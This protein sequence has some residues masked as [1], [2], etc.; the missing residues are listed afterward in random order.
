MWRGGRLVTSGP[1][2][3]DLESARH[4]LFYKAAR[5]DKNMSTEVASAFDAASSP[6]RSRDK[7]ASDDD[8]GARG[9]SDAGPDKFTHKRA[10]IEVGNRDMCY[11]K[12]KRKSKI[13]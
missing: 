3:G 8:H 11:R 6:K 4:H 7:V 9:A 1:Q 10:R 2:T 12:A 13:L 5:F